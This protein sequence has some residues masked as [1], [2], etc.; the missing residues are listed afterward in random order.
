MLLPPHPGAYHMTCSQESSEDLRIL[1]KRLFSLINDLPTVFEVV[2]E[3][4]P[5]KD[6]PTADSGS[7]SRSNKKRSSDGQVKSTPKLA[8]ESYEEEDDEHSETLCGSCGGNY[9]A[10]EFWIGCDIC[11]RFARSSG[12][13]MDSNQLTGTLKERLK[14]TNEL[15]ELFEKAVNQIGGPDRATPKGILKAMAI[16]GLT[17][18]HVKSHLQKYRMSI[19]TPEGG[20][21]DKSERRSISEEL[22]NFST[23]SGVQLNEALRMQR[24]A[25]RRWNDQIEVQKSLKMKIEAQGRFMDRIFEEYK[26]RAPS[27]MPNKPYPSVLSLPS[28]SEE[29]D[30]SNEKEFESDS[31]VETK[32]FEVE[33]RAPKKIR[34]HEEILPNFNVFPLEGMNNNPF[35][36]NDEIGLLPWSVGTFQSPLLPASLYNP[37]N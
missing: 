11:E 23:K 5:V 4:K 21:R 18:F 16:P 30:R 8:D 3:R 6:K 24:E 9:D 28:L 17:I 13:N 19:F 32:G 14:W 29:S 22:P 36:V 33:F 7:R 20:H 34:I 1:K 31:E 27:S 15:H 35:A 2:T 12:C 26:N 37:L 10:D 25:Q